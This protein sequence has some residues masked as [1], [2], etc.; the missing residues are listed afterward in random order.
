M[1]CSATN[2]VTMS[3]Q[4]PAVVS[5]PGAMKKVGIIDRSV[6]ESRRGVIGRI[7]QVFTLD[8]PEMNRR[9][10]VAGVN[11][12]LEELMKNDRFSV[13]KNLEIEQMENSAY[14]ALPAPLP[15]EDIDEICEDHNL[16]GLFLLEYYDTDTAIDYTAERVTIEAFGLGI[17]ALEHHATVQTD[18][19]T[20]WRIYDNTSRSI[21]DEFVIT[22]SIYTTGRGINPAEA[23]KA[24]TGRTEAIQDMSGHIGR[25]YG[26]SILPYWTRVRRDY[27][28]RGSDNLKLAK[29]RAQT[30]NW[31]G[32]AELWLNETENAKPKIAGRA[33]YNMAIINEI[34][35]DLD[36]AIEWARL[37]YENFGDK[38]ALRYLRILEDRKM[39]M[40]V[41]RRQ[42]VSGNTEV[43][44]KIPRNAPK[45]STGT[46]NG[47]AV[48]IYYKNYRLYIKYF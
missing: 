15:W 48:Q 29:R 21:I 30:G 20:G 25:D 28:V 32:A 22:E 41:L 10:A 16:D 14:G 8:G 39:S 4:E 27:Y 43:I 34:D 7:D 19:T 24:V 2:S 45:T 36:E 3:V 42:E 35:G 1:G 47:S 31:D 13:V 11:G 18:I 38:R 23:V 37:A 26:R 40:E 9:G 6:S 33:F 12:L 17:P 44:N 46:Q 5:M